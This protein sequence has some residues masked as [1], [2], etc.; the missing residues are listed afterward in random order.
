MYSKIGNLIWKEMKTQGYTQ[1]QLMEKLDVPGLQL[2]QAF[3]SEKIDAYL[4][5]QISKVLKKNFF[6]YLDAE[7]L[8]AVLNV[9]T[10]K[11]LKGKIV[12]LTELNQ[13]Q[14]VILHNLNIQIKRF[15]KFLQQLEKKKLS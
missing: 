6:Q 4:L 9:E 12:D 15:Q 11:Q 3:K 14:E 5:M 2:S 13:Q 7:E 8:D 1:V 10:I